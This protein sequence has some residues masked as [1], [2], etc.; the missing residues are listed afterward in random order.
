MIE[1][2]PPLHVV[3]IHPLKRAV[4]ADLFARA[5]PALR[6]LFLSAAF[7]GKRGVQALGFA[8]KSKAEVSVLRSSM[9]ENNIGGLL[10]SEIVDISCIG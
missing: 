4:R 2:L 8:A 9:R 7:G 6:Q 1:M 3:F 5:W 10:Y